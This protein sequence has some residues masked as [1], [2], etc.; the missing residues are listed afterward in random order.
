[1]AIL[2]F[3]FFIFIVSHSTVVARVI[4]AR[5]ARDR[6]SAVTA[7]H[8]SPLSPQTQGS[9]K[10]CTEILELFADMISDKETQARIMDIL[11]ELCLQLPGPMTQ[12][13]CLDQGK[14]ILPTVVHFLS[15]FIKTNQICTILGVCKS[16][17]QG[18]EQEVLTNKI[19]E[20]HISPGP[21]TMTWH[22]TPSSLQCTFCL[23]LFKS[24]DTLIPKTEVECIIVTVLSQICGILP[25]F[26]RG[27]CQSL[28]DRYVQRL[29]D[30]LLSWIT[31]RN[32]CRLLRFCSSQNTASPDCDSCQM[33]AML[34][35][36]HLGFNTTDLQTSAFLESVCQLY[37]SYIPKCDSFTLRYGPV[38]QKSLSKP[39]G[40]QNQC[41]EA[42]LCTAEEDPC[43]R[44]MDRCRDQETAEKCNSVSFCLR[45]MWR[46]EPQSQEQP[47]AL[48]GGM[49][50]EDSE[51][52]SP[53]AFH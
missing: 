23:L 21:G 8:F 7:A 39:G 35:R 50:T 36:F 31:P 20:I 22:E 41:E 5:T 19:A 38:L 17:S 52:D 10:D 29:L 28:V 3:V 47:I 6:L 43:R 48:N 14:H 15:D 34:A 30:F 45:Y 51:A 18:M 32:V 27:S 12:D 46:S 44:G 2:K 53:T 49:K 9:C 13:L 25:G 4:D 42:L 33:L 37:P 24:L 16:Q 26:L 40:I 11:K 1:M